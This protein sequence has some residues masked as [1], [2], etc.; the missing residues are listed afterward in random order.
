[1]PGGRL[2]RRET[3][4]VI[5]RVAH[6]RKCDY[7]FDHHVRLGRRAGLGAADIDR[8]KEGPDVEGWSEREQV[9]LRAVD[10]LHRDRN[11]DDTKW[12]ELRRHL[13]ERECIELIMLAGHYE[14]LATFIETLR[15]EPDSRS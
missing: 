15:I 10:Q 8:V 14:L 2:P 13:D 12:S 9:S 5:L 11:I 4:L 7:E 1:M 6:L 3:E